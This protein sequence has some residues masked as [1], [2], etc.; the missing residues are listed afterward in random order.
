MDNKT[1]ENLRKR[2]KIRLVNNAKGYKKR[3][4]RPT[5]VS[6]KTFSKNFVAIHENKLVLTLDKPIYVGF[7]NL[8]LSKL[9]MCEFH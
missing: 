4:S 1:I 5:F 6:Q 9:L 7:S 3:V 2:V 8:A